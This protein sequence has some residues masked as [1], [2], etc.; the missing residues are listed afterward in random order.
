MRPAFSRPARAPYRSGASTYALEHR[1]FARLDRRARTLAEAAVLTVAVTAAWVLALPAVARLWGHTLVVLAAGLD[2]PA[3]TVLRVHDVWGLEVAVP[4]WSMAFALPST[5]LLFGVGLGSLAL[6][7][8]TGFLAERW[9]PGVY[10]ARAVLLVQLSAVVYFALWPEHFPYTLADY[11]HGMMAT[12]LAITTSTPLVLGLTFYVQDLSR[13]QKVALTALAMGYSVVLVPLQYAL[14]GI[15]LASGT[16]LW[17]PTVYLFL[18]VPLHVFALVSLYAWGMSWEGRLPAL[19]VPAPAAPAPP[20]P[21]DDASDSSPASDSAPSIHTTTPSMTSPLLTAPRWLAVL[22]VALLLGTTAHAQTAL[23]LRQ[24]FEGKVGY[25]SASGTFRTQSNANNQCTVGT[26]STLNL[27]GIPTGATIRSAVLY[28]AGSGRTPDGTVLLDGATVTDAAPLTDLYVYDA[29]YT[30]YFFQGSADITAAV[31]SKR[32]AAYQLGGLTVSTGNITTSTPQEPYCATATVLKAWSIHVVYEDASMTRRSRVNLYDGFQVRLDQPFSATIDQFE[33]PTANNSSINYVIWEGDPNQGTGETVSFAAD[34]ATPVVLDSTD[35]FNQLPRATSGTEGS[36]IYSVDLDAYAISGGLPVGTTSGTFSAQA[37]SNDLVIVSSSVLQMHS[38]A[39]DL[40]V[41]LSTTDA[42][43]GL[44]GETVLYVDVANLGP[45]ASAAIATAVTI[46]AGYVLVATD[47]PVGTS[48]DA[49]TGI[50]TA[51]SGLAV[52][53]ST[54]LALSLRAETEDPVTASASATA[55]NRVED[56]LTNNIDT[57]GFDAAPEVDLSVQVSVDDDAALP[58]ETVTFTVAVTNDGPTDAT[59]VDLLGTI[60]GDLTVTG[61]SVTNGS[62]DAATGAWTLGDLASGETAYATV[63]ATVTGPTPGSLTAEVT[64]TNEPDVDST[65]NNAEAGEDDQDAATVTPAVADLALA[66]DVSD[67]APA[68]GDIVTFS[69]TVS[70]EEGIDASD[71]R[72][73]F[74]VYDS[75]LLTV[76]GSSPEVGAWDGTIWTVGDLAVGESRT[77]TVQV[78][79]L[80]DLTG[81]TALAEVSHADQ[82]DVDS[83]PNNGITSEDD[84]ASA[85]A[86][87]GGA[88]TAGEGG[89]ESNGSM[90]QA[91]ASVLYGRR[92]QTAARGD[93]GLPAPRLVPL[94]EARRSQARLSSSALALAVPSFGPSESIAVEVSPTDLLPVTNAIDVVAADYL[95]A[96]GRR[97]GAIFATATAPGEVYE[98]TKPVC[99][100]LRGGVLDGVERVSVAGQPFVLT[101]LTQADGSVDYA[102]SFVVYRTGDQRVVDSRFLLHEYDTA[103][104]ADAEVLNFQAW[105]PSREYAAALVAATLAEL[106]GEGPLRFRNQGAQAPELPTV[107]VRTG[108]YEDGHLVLDLYNAAGAT[109]LRLT[110]GTMTRAEGAAPVPFTQTVAVPGGSPDEPFVTVA[111]ETGALFDAAFFVETDQSAAPDRLYL[112]DGTWGVALDPTS[113]AAR[114]DAFEVAPEAGTPLDGVRRVERAVRVAGQMDSFATLYR[115]LAPGGGALDLSPYSYVEFEAAGSGEVQ[116]LLQ[117]ASI[118][119]SDHFG[120]TVRLTP[121]PTRHR[122]YFED[123]HLADG[124]RGFDG[125]DVVTL[126]L[127]ARTAGASA[128]DLAVQDVRFGGAEGDAEAAAAEVALLTPVPNP[129]GASARLRF[130]LATA[131]PAT[132]RVYD[133]LGR[134]V[135]RPVDGELAAGRH[136]VAIDGTGLAAGVYVVRLDADGRTLTQRMTRVR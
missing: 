129:F 94:A 27:T 56:D 18:G 21:E 95:R 113:E 37:A 115:T 91:L 1:A 87:T 57:L 125:T 58:G 117:Q 89:L 54:Q 22:A 40:E 55:T 109:S 112:A 25:T 26:T 102:I 38:L 82:T 121:E 64:A 72:V 31:A 24:G 128:F 76:V 59:G 6:F 45:D 127:T 69:V 132:L 32:N 19:G 68:V 122:I 48:Y 66:L 29:T 116:V 17:M 114:L 133:V 78:Q 4:Y 134:E 90:A 12:G 111:V 34:A 10:L 42:T 14:H 73:S 5:L 107:F 36:A 8:A 52:G 103:A 100:R 13:S 70:N 44:M 105:G 63:T 15:A 84:Y 62:Y 99:D 60:A 61:L 124:T 126:S 30:M 39:S 35:P 49:A 23:S 83:D 110:G 104:M 80:Q 136:T 77:L 119:T 92:Q 131:G 33:T 135:A 88:S 74:P 67:P 28:W 20:R 108:R 79:L 46:P 47:A 50:W 86:S 106:S 2:A 98:H 85:S 16:A 93:A 101:R 118:A 11:L 97:V 75:A 7:L 51:P 71:V 120:A 9:R 123:L 130:D 41:T 3:E 65:P 81:Y 43:P 96:D 53:A